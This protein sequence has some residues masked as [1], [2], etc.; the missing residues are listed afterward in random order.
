[1]CPKSGL[2]KLKIEI[3]EE[4]KQFCE[5]THC[6]HR[7]ASLTLQPIRTSNLVKTCSILQVFFASFVQLKANC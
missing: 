5:G 2:A 6:E 3:N 4:K 7:D 1:M